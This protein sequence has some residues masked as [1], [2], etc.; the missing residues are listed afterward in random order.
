MRWVHLPRYRGVA[1]A[2]PVVADEAVG[3]PANA[4]RLPF[5]GRRSRFGGVRLVGVEA[6]LGHLDEDEVGEAP[7]PAATCLARHRVRGTDAYEP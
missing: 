1:P 7:L 5:G 3:A 2:G 4:V 6:G